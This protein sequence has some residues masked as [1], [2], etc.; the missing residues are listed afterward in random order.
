VCQC[1]LLSI[2]S[3]VKASYL[4][5]VSPHS[6]LLCI[7]RWHTAHVQDERERPPVARVI[8]SRTR[9]RPHASSHVPCCGPQLRHVHPLEEPW[10][11]HQDELQTA[12]KAGRVNEFRAYGSMLVAHSLA[13]GALGL[14]ARGEICGYAECSGCALLVV[15]VVSIQ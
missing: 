14:V 7:S 6:R 5:I 10:K 3:L 12:R 15:F 13:S 11:E 1:A 8:C 9:R 2:V 4:I